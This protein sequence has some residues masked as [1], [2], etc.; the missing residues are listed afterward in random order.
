MKE[1]QKV[2]LSPSKNRQIIAPKTASG[3]EGEGGG[4][5]SNGW[6]K[7]FFTFEIQYF[8][9]NFFGVFS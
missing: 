7:I 3:A 6:F 8:Y 1:E 2:R 5:Q 4:A 9:L